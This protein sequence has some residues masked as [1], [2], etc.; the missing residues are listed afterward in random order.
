M[1]KQ[2]QNKA[3]LLDTQM[4]ITSILTKD[5]ENEPLR[6]RGEN[7][8]KQTQFFSYPNSPA[9]LFQP[10]KFPASFGNNTGFARWYY[11]LAPP[12]RAFAQGGSKNVLKKYLFLRTFAQNVRTFASFWSTFAHFCPTFHSNLRKW[13]ENLRVCARFFHPV[14][15]DQLSICRNNSPA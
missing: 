6:R 9:S 10:I 5:Y 12:A 2:I 14:L 3:N 1:K 13:F 11:S 7:K 4:N 15:T 8:P